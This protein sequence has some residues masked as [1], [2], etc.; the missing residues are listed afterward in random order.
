MVPKNFWFLKI[1]VKKHLESEKNSELKV[2]KHILGPKFL[3]VPQNFLN[4]PIPPW[5]YLPRSDLTVPNW[6]DQSWLK[7][8]CPNFTGPDPTWP[9]HFCPVQI[10]PVQNWPVP[11]WP[12]T[13]TFQ[14]ALRHLQDSLQ[15]RHQRD[16]DQDWEFLSPNDKTETE[17]KNVWV[18]M[19]GPRLRLNIKDVNTKTSLRLSLISQGSA[20]PDFDHR[21]RICLFQNQSQ[22]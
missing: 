17:T 1:L 9:V 19:T 4:R 7:L 14:T 15:I 3:F 18:S 21:I 11:T 12:F 6:L 20:R 22:T 5:F 8:T 13:D 10:W 2:L 16:R